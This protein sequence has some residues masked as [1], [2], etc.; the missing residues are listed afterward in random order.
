MSVIARQGNL[1]EEPDATFIVNASNTE[2]VLGSGVSAAFR[3]H[4]GDD[5]YQQYL[6]TC[7]T[8]YEREHGPIQQ[9]DVVC[10]GAGTARNIR[11]VLHGAVMDYSSGKSSMPT[12]HTVEKIL[13]GI[14][15]CISRMRPSLP[16]DLSRIK[17]V[18]PLMGT[19]VGG[20]DKRSVLESYARHLI[21]MARELDMDIVVYGYSRDDFFLIRAALK[22]A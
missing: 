17:L 15:E 21:P 5:E 22:G 12:I 20:L 16:S 7:K 19:G 11:N 8:A 18:L 10:T 3:A 1:V 4:C 13:E 14:G 2:L 9:G 6:H